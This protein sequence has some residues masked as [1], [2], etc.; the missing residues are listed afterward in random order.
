M[1][2]P[3]DSSIRAGGPL[4]YTLVPFVVQV[5]FLTMLGNEMMDHQAVAQLLGNYGE[6]IGSIAVLVTLVYLSVQV[7]QAKHEVSLVGRQA[8][9]NLAANVLS[10]VISS[11]E[12]ARI[13]AKLKMLNYGDFGLTDEESIRFGAWFHTWLQEQQGHFYLLPEGE[14]DPMLAWLLSNPAGAEF[15]ERNKGVYD[16]P[17][18]KRIE[19]IKADLQSNPMSEPEILGGSFGPKIQ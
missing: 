9:A 12:F 3:S 5:P 7:R 17:F 18:V 14:N 6:F 10:P 13:F 16:K 11:P 15:F 4:T 2:L 19:A 8:R 1:A